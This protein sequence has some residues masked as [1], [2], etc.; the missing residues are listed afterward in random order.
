MSEG[1]TEVKRGLAGVIAD[2]TAV[3]VIDEGTGTLLYRGYPVP[4]LA[5][6]CSFEEVAYLIW[7]G[8]LPNTAQ[9]QAFTAAERSHHEISETSSSLCRTSP[10][11][12]TRWTSC[13]PQ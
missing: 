10:R 12:A 13:G 9:L 3:S 8:E 1:T 4:D 5:T 6:S 7:H 2:T 11:P